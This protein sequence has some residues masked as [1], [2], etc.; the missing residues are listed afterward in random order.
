MSSPVISN[1]S[2]APGLLAGGTLNGSDFLHPFDADLSAVS[3]ITNGFHFE[4]LPRSGWVYDLDLWV[5]AL[6]ETGNMENGYP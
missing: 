1:V 2:P 5:Y 6:D 3:A 4:V